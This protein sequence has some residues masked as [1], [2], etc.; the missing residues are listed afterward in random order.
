MESWQEDL[1]HTFQ[2]IDCEH[3]LFRTLMSFA[4]KLGFEWCAYGLRSPFPVVTPKTLM[5]NNYPS[6]WQNRYKEANYLAVDP[7]VS[8]GLRSS[9]PI[10][11]NDQIFTSTRN[12]WEEA[13]SFGL[14]HGWAQSTREGQSMVGMLTLARSTE[15][16][17]SA[18]LRANGQQMTWLNQA[19]HTAMV[20]ILHPKMIPEGAVQLSPREISVLRWTADGKTSADISEILKISER[21]VNFHIG[22]SI[23][24]L[25]AANKT[26]ATVRAALLGIL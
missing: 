13:R 1:L 7:T 19:T 21:T 22:N 14:R 24:K 16:V 15:G 17:S 10:V 6:I 4:S 23:I 26:A 20:R 3:E 2:S 11:W 9:R 18:E 5:L 8:H 12:F 25:N